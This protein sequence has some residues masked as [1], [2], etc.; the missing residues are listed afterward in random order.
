MTGWRG[1]LDEKLDLVALESRRT[2]VARVL[3]A[4]GMFAL[5]SL[6]LGIPIGTI[7]VIAALTC[8][9]C[10]WSAAAPQARGQ[11]PAR[12][13]RLFYAGSG[14]AQTIVWSALAV[15]YWQTSKPALE[16]VAVTVLAVQ[17]L[18]ASTF[19]FHSRLALFMMGGPPA[20]CQFMLPLLFSRYAGVQQLTL[21]LGMSIPVIYAV[22]AARENFITMA[23]LESSKLQLKVQISVAVAANQAKTAFLAMMSH[24]LRTPMNGV[25][26]MAHALKTTDLNASQASHVDMLL[27]SGD[28]LLTILDDILDISKIEADK[29]D[30][31]IKPFDLRE[32]GAHVYDLW[33]QIAQEKGV[34]LLYEFDPVSPAWVLGDPRASARS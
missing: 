2:A 15:L 23:A 27:K 1:M 32:L 19:G 33:V 29:F 10:T 7:W 34:T 4:L 31:E 20:L 24:E 6:N 28:G 5:L 26:G 30:L 25:L 8:E 14:L 21:G 16:I 17:L 11:I 22:N 13:Q 12:W 3:S 18:H 9:G